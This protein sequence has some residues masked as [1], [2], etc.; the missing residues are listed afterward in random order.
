M[1]NYYNILGV[2]ESADSNEI[3]RS[4]RKLSMKHHPDRGGSKETFQKINEAY[5]ILGEESKRKTYDMQRNSP[6]GNLFSENGIN[7]HMGDMGDMGAPSS[8]ARDRARAT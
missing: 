4:F 1:E 2:N 8:C 3:K 7:T 5:Q 6:F